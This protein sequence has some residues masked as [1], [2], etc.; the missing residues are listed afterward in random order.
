MGG[1]VQLEDIIADRTGV[2]DD[3]AVL[4]VG[5]HRREGLFG[6]GAF[7]PQTDFGLEPGGE[8]HLQH[9]EHVEAAFLVKELT[10]GKLLLAHV[11]E[12]VADQQAVVALL[13]LVGPADLELDRVDAERGRQTGQLALEGAIEHPL[14]VGG[15]DGVGFEEFVPSVL[16]EGLLDAV[17]SESV[18][19]R[20]G[21]ELERF[22]Q[23]LF[24]LRR[25][26]VA[27][28][29]ELRLLVF[30]VGVAE[31]Q[32]ADRTVA[33]EHKGVLVLFTAGAQVVAVEAQAG[34]VTRPPGQIAVER[35]VGAAAAVLF[36]GAFDGDR[37]RGIAEVDQAAAVATA[38]DFVIEAD[39]VFL[40][41]FL[42]GVLVVEPALGVEGH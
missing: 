28:L 27:V 40:E 1:G 21:L 12:V 2:R 26:A 42:D 23:D 10:V 19:P 14:G 6:V 11:V 31:I 35:Q 30:M 29:V 24:E 39:R 15:V 17:V 5:E 20:L 8:L 3:E 25:D 22:G 16:V 41:H 4:V 13:V 33:L 36:L 37:L 38:V 7:T 18:D 9:G 34:G 32:T